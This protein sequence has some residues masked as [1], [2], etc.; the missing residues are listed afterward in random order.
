MQRRP[1]RDRGSDS[2]RAR[3]TQPALPGATMPTVSMVAPLQQ[4][5]AR[6]YEPQ[7]PAKKRPDYGRRALLQLLSLGA[8]LEVLFLA[9]YPLFA[10]VTSGNDAAKQ[11]LP[12]LASA[13][14]TRSP[15]SCARISSSASRICRC[16]IIRA[17]AS[18]LPTA[19]RTFSPIRVTVPPGD[20]C[21]ACS[22]AAI[23]APR[24]VIAGSRSSICSITS[25]AS[26]SW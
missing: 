26:S 20:F 19:R 11:A 23:C 9:L 17:R 22:R 15:A 13:I 5:P 25:T 10:G 7:S 2:I 6:L 8:L 4:Y 14:A 24:R 21:A 16:A 18:S 12:G 1:G 3:R